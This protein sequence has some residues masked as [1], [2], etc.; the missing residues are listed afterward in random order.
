[1]DR[2][3]R[4]FGGFSRALEPP[5]S[6]RWAQAADK[7]GAMG[8]S[9]AVAAIFMASSLRMPMVWDEGNAIWRAEGITAWYQQVLA[10]PPERWTKAF[11]PDTLKHFW[12][13]TTTL[14][15]HPSFYG[16]TIALGRSLAPQKLSPWQQAR[17]GPI[18][19]FAVA[20]GFV[21]WY[22]KQQKGVT[23][24]LA[25]VVGML[26]LPHFFAHIQFATPDSPLCSLWILTCIIFC[27]WVL[28]PAVTHTKP[29]AHAN[30]NRPCLVLLNLVRLC[31]CY[32]VFGIVL[33]LTM[34]T[35]FTG[36][37]APVPFYL[38]AIIRKKWQELAGL[39]YAQV[40]ATLVFIL[41]NPPI[42]HDP[43]RGMLEFVARNLDRS[44]YNVSIFFLGQRYDL[45]HPLPW[46][47]TLVWVAVTVPTFM[48]ICLGV[49]LIACLRH[50]ADRPW[51]G[52]MILHMLWLLLVRATPWAPPHDGVRL[53]LPSIGFMGILGGLGAAELIRAAR[54]CLVH[55]PQSLPRQVSQ[56]VGGGLIVLV[57]AGSLSCVRNFCCY[58]PHW[59][60]FYN[61]LVGGPAEA[62]RLGLEVT[63][64]WD[65]LTPEVL[66][67]LEKNTGEKEKV[68]FAAG[69]YENLLL[70]QRWRYISFQFRPDAPG[71]WRWYVL[72]HRFGVWQPADWWLVYNRRPVFTK[73]LFAGKGCQQRDVIL[74]SIYRWEDYL[75]ALASVQNDPS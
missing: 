56:L 7:L 71:Q 55:P 8:V 12:R 6:H 57:I 63:Y 52:L 34:A 32:G 35:K 24:G 65:S 28:N 42:W 10:S 64:Y 1:M 27:A 20:S 17:V 41:V 3:L 31:G 58:A 75:E 53:F 2:C 4:W 62:Q 48:L 23:A 49:T 46:Y 59:L 43:I 30:T 16:I 51:L 25:A 33:G 37:L 69:P 70:L 13:Y 61:A 14:E 54:V 74:L 47:N 11:K 50:Q 19:L 68:F 67:W 21:Y 60:S 44:D 18:V 66:Q 38:W 73:T 9:A 36:F 15:G 39:L 22:L 29:L 40:V 5:L 72:Q 45:Y 26:F